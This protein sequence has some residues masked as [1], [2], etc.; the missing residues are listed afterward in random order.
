MPYLMKYKPFHKPKFI[1]ISYIINFYESATKYEHMH[2]IQI[3]KSGR[4]S[5]HSDTL[6]SLTARECDNSA[7]QAMRL[8]I[9]ERKSANT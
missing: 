4:G 3:L 5:F 2:H 7:R 1:I 6:H 9:R 8:E